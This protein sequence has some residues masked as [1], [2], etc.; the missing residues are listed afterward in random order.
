MALIELWTDKLLNIHQFRIN[1]GFISK[2]T[3]LTKT[4]LYQSFDSVL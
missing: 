3:S 2:P 1:K 4:V